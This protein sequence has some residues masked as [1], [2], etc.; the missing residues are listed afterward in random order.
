MDKELVRYGWITLD[1]LE[2]RK[3]YHS[4]DTKDGEL[5]T[6]GIVKTLVWYADPEVK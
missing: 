5:R 6:V 4:A 3:P 2:M 1:V